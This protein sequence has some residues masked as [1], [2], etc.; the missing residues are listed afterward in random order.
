MAGKLLDREGGMASTETVRAARTTT[1]I[2]K[3]TTAGEL[4]VGTLRKRVRQ[5]SS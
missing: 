5:G 1:R 4:I 2:E 3:K